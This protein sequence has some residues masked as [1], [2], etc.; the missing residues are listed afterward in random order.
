MTD[1][2]S[3]PVRIFERRKNKQTS[4][5]QTPF[6]YMQRGKLP[7]SGVLD[8]PTLQGKDDR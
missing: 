8:H 3:T 4:E 1:S 2:D 5:K 6:S 7:N